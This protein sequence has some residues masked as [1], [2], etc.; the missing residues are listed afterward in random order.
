MISEEKLLFD[1]WRT[2][3]KSINPDGIINKKL[4]LEC[5]RKIL[6]LLKEANNME[7]EVDFV[8]F[9]NNGAYGR[10]P[11]WENIV[12]WIYGLQ[13]MEKTISW[14]ELE[15]LFDNI[16][17]RTDLL[18]KIIFCNLK[19]TNGGHTTINETF[20]DICFED[21][22][23]ITKQILLYLNNEELC[24]E[25]IISGGSIVTST[26]CDLFDFNDDEIWKRTS[27]GIYF[28]EIR[29]KKYF[30][31]FVHPEVRV[32]PNFI[33]YTLIEAIKEILITGN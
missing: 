22:E 5:D 8:E 12:R 33:Y 13:N 9:L 17:L 27:N 20:Y 24:P 18:K 31:D 29:P 28:F 23:F 15:K 1:S 4:Y 19:K 2:K 26:F 6:V 25:I 10:K 7:G 16:E 30:V 21:K 14:S 3:R 32:P 11:T